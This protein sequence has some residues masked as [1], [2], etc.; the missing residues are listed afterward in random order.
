MTALRGSSERLRSLLFALLYCAV[1]LSL[2]GCV[3]QARLKPYAGQWV[4]RSSGKDMMVLN[5]SV[6]GGRIAGTL[7]APE[8]FTENND[9]SFDGMSLQVETRPVTGRWKKG[10]VELTVGKRPDQDKMPMTLPDK[11][12]ALLD[13]THGK[14][15]PWR[16]ERASGGR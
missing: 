11:D 14:V 9:S 16:F 15:P 2:S 4:L 7:T 12:H 13:W 5:T 3:R 1:C 6:Q 10:L 8:H